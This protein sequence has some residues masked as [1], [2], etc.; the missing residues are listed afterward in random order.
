ML[1]KHR[2]IYIFP[3]KSSYAF[4]NGYICMASYDN[5]DVY[6][7]KLKIIFSKRKAFPQSFTDPFQI[8]IWNIFSF[9]VLNPING[10]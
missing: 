10:P 8:V 1:L 4:L 5:Y 9:R 6:K 3:T 7:I 2:E